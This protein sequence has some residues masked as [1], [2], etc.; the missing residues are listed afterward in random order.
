MRSTGSPKEAS[1]W[2]LSSG[3]VVPSH[4]VYPWPRHRYH[5]LETRRKLVEVVCRPQ[6]LFAVTQHASRWKDPCGSPAQQWLAQ[7]MWVDLA[8]S[9]WH[10]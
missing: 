9:Y 6:C 4:S 5:H 10:L 3:S 7:D 8:A 2:C 1:A